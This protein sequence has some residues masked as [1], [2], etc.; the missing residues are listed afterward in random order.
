MTLL[1]AAA[2]LPALGAARAA[3]TYELIPAPPGGANMYGPQISSSGTVVVY[4]A[5]VNDVGQVWA[6]DRKTHRT[7]LVSAAL[8]DPTA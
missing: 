1:V 3:G 4:A 8:G 2:L 5:T 6:Y 7:E